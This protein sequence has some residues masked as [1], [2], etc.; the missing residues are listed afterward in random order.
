MTTPEATIVK[1]RRISLVW[2]FPIIALGL[3]IWMIAI[4]ELQ[5]G[6]VITIE[7]ND[8]GGI[9]A[10][11]TKVKARSVVIGSVINVELSPDFRK[12]IVKARINKSY[13]DLLTD[14]ASIWIVKPRFG[15]GGISGVETILSG[16][17]V[18]LAPGQ[19]KKHTLSF[20]GLELPPVSEDGPGIHV[21]LES[22]NAHALNVGDPVLYRGFS[23]G[24][25]Q[26]ASFDTEHRLFKY[27]VFIRDTFTTLVTSSTRFWNTTALDIKMDSQ[28]ISFKVASID[29]LLNGGVSFDTLE[30]DDKG[31]PVEEGA[32]FR[33]F[34]SYEKMILQPY[35]Y[36]A[37]Y[38]LLFDNSVRG[39]SVGSPVEYRGIRIGTVEGIS[40]DYHEEERFIAGKKV[41]IP[42]LIRI[43]PGRFP[44]GDTEE[45]LKRLETNIR[46]R[47]ELGLRASLSTGNLLTGGLFVN[48]DYYEDTP[49]ETDPETLAG[50]SVFP[51]VPSGAAEIENRVLSILDKMDRLPLESAVDEMEGSF[52]EFKTLV[53]SLQDILT[54][55]EPELSQ[56]KIGAILDTVQGALTEFETTMAG[57]NSRS[58]LYRQLNETL[59]EI[60][61]AAER[62]EALGNRLSAKPNALIFSG[63]ANDDPKPASDDE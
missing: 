22:E 5:K 35:H 42:V 14:D 41:S 21:I 53:L 3:G 13:A 26:E 27:T 30:Q 8:S 44:Y 57:M 63:S 45:G 56:E 55:L 7:F 38:M 1:T 48:F 36:A 58:P 23:V 49:S 19:S 39:L 32:H 15:S 33:L 62:I 18:E 50:Y 28:G 17:Y 24:K 12:V 59:E 31:Q 51:T 25:I 60:R 20:V 40:L 52:R 16:S 2:L 61:K 43:D 4:K 29:S 54:E 34:D 46:S 10:E 9:V 47:V 6:L 11:K 37:R